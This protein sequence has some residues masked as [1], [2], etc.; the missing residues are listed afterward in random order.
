M[1]VKDNFTSL[2]QKYMDTVFRLA[3]SY[4]KSRAD[5]DDVTQNVLLALYRTDK[6]FESEAHVKN[7]LIRVTVNECKKLFRSPW[8]RAEDID[9]YVSSLSFEDRDSRALFDAI[10]ALDKKYRAVIVLHY[11]EG[12]SIREMAEILGAPTG[13]VGV[14]LSRARERLKLELTEA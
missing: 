11:Y 1:V 14:W 4:L 7:W 8:R 3:F 2:V 5:A 6:A 13:T 9:A 12:Y 10:M